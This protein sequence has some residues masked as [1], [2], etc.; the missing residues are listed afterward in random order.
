[1]MTYYRAW[2]NQR[3]VRGLLREKQPEFAAALEAAVREAPCLLC[4]GIRCSPA[5]E[6]ALPR[7]PQP[8]RHLAPAGHT[9]GA[10]H[11]GGTARAARLARPARGRKPQPS[12]IQ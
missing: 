11:T 1:M 2:E 3:F 5:D 10:G 4:D 8:R 12:R 7:P 9:N 6:P